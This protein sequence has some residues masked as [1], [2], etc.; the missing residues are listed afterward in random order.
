MWFDKML[1]HII[2]KHNSHV[3]PPNHENSRQTWPHHA[4]DVYIILL[5]L[6]YDSNIIRQVWCLY[7]II[8]NAC[9]RHTVCYL[10]VCYKTQQEKKTRVYSNL[11]SDFFLTLSQDIL[12][13]GGDDYRQ[14]IICLGSERRGRGTL[15]AAQ[16]ATDG[17]GRQRRRRWRRADIP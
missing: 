11:I 1:R 15:E 2:T 14:F 10:L 17:R 9:K 16:H 13:V 5:R 7:I 12:G 6:R 8:L 3:L 4:N